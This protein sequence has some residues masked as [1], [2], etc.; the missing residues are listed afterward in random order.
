MQDMQK[1]A[2]ELALALTDALGRLHI[3]DLEKELELLLKQTADPALWEDQARAQG[4]MKKQSALDG[5]IRPWRELEKS[6][7][8]IQELLSMNDETLLSDLEIQLRKL[9]P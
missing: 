2:N 3:G 7:M 5:R 6:V 1:Q 9:R 4:L 8:D